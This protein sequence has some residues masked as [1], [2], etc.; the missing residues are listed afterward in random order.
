MS[1]AAGVLAEL[2]LHDDESRLV[3]RCGHAEL[4]RQWI[5]GPPRAWRF[6]LYDEAGAELLQAEGPD[7]ELWNRLRQRYLGLAPDPLGPQTAGPATDSTRSPARSLGSAATGLAGEG[8]DGRARW[9][10]RDRDG[11]VERHR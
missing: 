4:Q 3:A 11:L 6:R 8:H 1:D 9:Q 5:D 7:R 10:G 2:G